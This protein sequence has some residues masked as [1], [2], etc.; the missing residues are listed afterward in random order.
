V[1][2]EAKRVWGGKAALGPPDDLSWQERGKSQ[3]EKC[4]KLQAMVGL[5]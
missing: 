3:L 2:L 4:E 1:R 5:E